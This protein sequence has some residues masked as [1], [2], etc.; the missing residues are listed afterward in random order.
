MEVDGESCKSWAWWLDAL[1]AMRMTYSIPMD[2]K[3]A[4]IR[5]DVA[6]ATLR[7]EAAEALRKG[8]LMR[9][10]GRRRDPEVLRVAAE[11]ASRMDRLHDELTA[12]S[13][14]GQDQGPQGS[15][16]PGAAGRQAERDVPEDGDGGETG[17]ERG[18]VGRRHGGPRG[19][20][21]SQQMEILALILPWRL[22]RRHQ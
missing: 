22:L 3:E 6:E 16:V 20:R 12:V 9:W 11:E 15:G 7:L 17:Q 10:I 4:R 19:L 5:A 1:Q 21:I 18:P 14:M 8:Q 13:R 2:A